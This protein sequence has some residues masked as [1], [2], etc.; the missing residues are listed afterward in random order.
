M[1]NYDRS[2][3]LLVSSALV[4]T[5]A[6]NTIN[7]TTELQP[8]S[9]LTEATTMDI[10]NSM[11]SPPNSPA[12]VEAAESMTNE[13]AASSAPPPSAIANNTTNFPQFVI[14]TTTMN[15]AT[16]PPPALSLISTLAVETR[17]PIYIPNLSMTI[18]GQPPALLFAL[19]GTANYPVAQREYKRINFV[20]SDAN[21]AAFQRM[22][23]HGKFKDILFLN[24]RSDSF[25]TFPHV[26]RH[27]ISHHV[28][29]L[30]NNFLTINFTATSPPNAALAANAT[31]SHE[32]VANVDS[33]L[34]LIGQM[35]VAS[36]QPL[37]ERKIRVKFLDHQ[38]GN[39][40]AASIQR[41]VATVEYTLAAGAGPTRSQR[42]GRREFVGD[43]G[44]VHDG[45]VWVWDGL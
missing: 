42:T 10:G 33:I 35:M 18:A 44:V 9:A 5:T 32:V 45:I 37:R 26:G 4:G 25:T 30:M 21:F 28:T 15:N 2:N 20:L 6:I 38:G 27:P 34:N 11:T 16:A 3:E 36:Q 39:W 22:S 12:L 23:R 31:R 29:K 24:I 7:I 43:G 14:V 13:S 17:I 40:S 19:K 41:H 1:D 8:P